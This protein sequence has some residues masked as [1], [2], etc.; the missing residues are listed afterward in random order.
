MWWLTC[1]L[2]FGLADDGPTGPDFRHVLLLLPTTFTGGLVS[3]AG[4]ECVFTNQLYSGTGEKGVCKHVCVCS[5]VHMYGM[6]WMT[7]YLH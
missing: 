3:S 4:G 6:V 1:C 2:W 5:F 7:H